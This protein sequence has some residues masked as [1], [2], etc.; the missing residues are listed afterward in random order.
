MYLSSGQH[1]I[2]NTNIVTK[3]SISIMKNSLFMP[4]YEFLL[5]E[6]PAR[7]SESGT[8]LHWVNNVHNPR[9]T[10]GSYYNLQSISCVT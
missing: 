7:I 1:K 5:S 3:N 6:A 10:N 9:T 2:L 4:L 8:N